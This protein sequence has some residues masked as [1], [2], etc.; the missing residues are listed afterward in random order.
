[1]HFQ[2]QGLFKYL[3]RQ[4]TPLIRASRDHVEFTRAM[5]IFPYTPLVPAEKGFF[6]HGHSSRNSI[7]APGNHG[8]DADTVHPR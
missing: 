5:A 4:K 8:A 2:M 1:M 7:A 3:F 6:H